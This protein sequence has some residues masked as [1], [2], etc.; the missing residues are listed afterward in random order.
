MKNQSNNPRRK[1]TNRDF[2]QEKQLLRLGTRQ[3][4][5]GKCGESDPV[6]LTGR[7][8]KIV[9][10]ECQLKTAKRSQTEHHH[11]AKRKNDP[12]TI[13]IPGNDHRYLTD[14]QEDWPLETLRNPNGSPL[15]KA[16]ATIRGWL[17]VL[18]LLIERVFGWIPEFLEK[19]DEKLT[20]RLGKTWW[21]ALGIS[22]EIAR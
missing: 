4:Q 21:D 12:F 22:A 18:R 3:P 8:P 1:A 10:Y 19:L 2:R 15:R 9:C 16:S 14:L 20:E 6:T 17:D 7:Q 11:P 5:C 13:C